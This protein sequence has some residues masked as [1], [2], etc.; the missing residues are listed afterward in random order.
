MNRFCKLIILQLFIFCQLTN[1]QT[2]VRSS[3]SCLGSTFTENGLILLQTMGQ[4][5]GTDVL[6]MGGMELRQGFQQPVSAWNPVK[7]LNPVDFT[8]SPN[9]AKD[10]TL[11]SFK[12]E[13]SGCVVYIRDINGSLLSKYSTDILYEKRV[14]LSGIKPGIYFVTIGFPN[15]HSTKKLIVSN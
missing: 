11:I 15:G 13:I 4:P 2:I 5:S 6:R 14:D 1:G 10:F 12:E 7:E 9:P 8:I 3:F